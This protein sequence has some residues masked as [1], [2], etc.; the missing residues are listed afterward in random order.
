MHFFS[1]VTIKEEKPTFASVLGSKD[2]TGGIDKSVES[3]ADD[4]VERGSVD[5]ASNAE[6]KDQLFSTNGSKE[7]KSD[8]LWFL[9][10]LALVT[11]CLGSM[12]KARI[13]PAK[14]QSPLTG[15]YQ[16]RGNKIQSN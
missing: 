3:D 2:G 7:L 5:K 15:R 12:P 11:T 13:N 6:P 1:D 4:D 10:L 14:F 9:V 16:T 8:R